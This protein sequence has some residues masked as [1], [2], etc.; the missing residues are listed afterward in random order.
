MSISIYR[1]NLLSKI[2]EIRLK[3]CMNMPVSK[4]LDH[5]T[6]HFRYHDFCKIETT[7]INSAS[8]PIYKLIWT[9][10]MSWVRFPAKMSFYNFCGDLS[11]LNEFKY[12]HE[13]LNTVV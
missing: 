2:K 8:K 13:I 10:F 3:I 4:V 9:N 11:F 5:I 6:W 1:F 12:Q 7:L